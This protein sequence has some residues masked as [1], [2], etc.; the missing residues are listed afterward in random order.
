MIEFHAA[1]MWKKTQA[2]FEEREQTV[3]KS[4]LFLLGIGTGAAAVLTAKASRPLGA[5]AVAGGMLAYEAACNAAEGS[6]DT[7]SASSERIR[8]KLK[9]VPQSS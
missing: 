8:D 5:Y 2:D 3:T 6:R 7:L 4:M 1:W 9:R